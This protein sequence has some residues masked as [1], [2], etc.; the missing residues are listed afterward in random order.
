M[1]KYSTSTGNYTNTNCNAVQQIYDDSCAIKSQQLILNSNGIDI[2]EDQLC[3]EAFQNGWY[4]PGDGTP[5]DHIDNLI[6]THGLQVERKIGGTIDDLRFKTTQGHNVIVGV[7]SGELWHKG[8][9]E[10]FEDI[11]QGPRADHALLVS[12][13]AINPL[14]GNEDILLTD[15]GTGEL[16]ANYPVNQFED[17]WDDSDN[18]MVSIQDDF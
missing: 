9:H 14:T 10:T 8:I 2:T 5:I 16:F 11:I 18:F 7:D 3:A 13:F 17:A 1:T 12:G 6:E 4:K 15:P